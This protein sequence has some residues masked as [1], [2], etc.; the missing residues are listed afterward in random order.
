[1]SRG[2]RA[3]CCPELAAGLQLAG[4]EP[5]ITRD[6]AQAAASIARLREEGRT[7]VILVQQSLHAQL[8]HHRAALPLLVALPDPIATTGPSAAEEE[9]L[10]IVRRAVGYRVR[11]R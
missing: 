8:P 1:M 6:P 7:A 3:I 4:L 11:L 9:L 5:E 10:E 2:L